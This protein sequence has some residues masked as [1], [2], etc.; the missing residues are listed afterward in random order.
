MTRTIIPPHM[1]DRP[2]GAD[3]LPFDPADGYPRVLWRHPERRVGYPCLH[4]TSVGPD[5]VRDRVAYGETVEQVAH[6]LSLNPEHVRA[7]LSP[8]KRKKVKA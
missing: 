2:I 8:R 3:G 5:I 6:D 7:V 4:G 1:I